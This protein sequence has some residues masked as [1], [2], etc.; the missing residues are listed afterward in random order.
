MGNPPES[1]R[2]IGKRILRYGSITSTNDIARDLARERADEGTVVVADEQTLGRGS[3]GRKWI[4]PAGTNLLLSV[5][6]RPSIPFERVSELAFVASLGVARFLVDS[7]GLDAKIKWPND[8]RVSGGK[9][10][11]VLIEVVPGR[12]GESPAAVVG[13]GLNVNWADLPAE[14]A[15]SATSVLLETGRS[16]DLELALHGLLDSLDKAYATYI[17]E[18]F[19]SILAQWKTLECVTGTH[20]AVASD[21]GTIEGRVESVDPDGALVIRLEDGS[22]RRVSAASLILD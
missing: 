4:S 2:L 18:G 6:V 21:E 1:I 17:G 3:R 8:V 22:T 15:P 12:Q 20:I 11:G 5:I 7:L 16:T 13:I 10:A 14:I 9:I 19:E